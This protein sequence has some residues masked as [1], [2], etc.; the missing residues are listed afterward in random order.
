[1]SGM[2]SN[3]P[4]LNLKG[5]GGGAGGIYRHVRMEGIAR[6]DGSLVCDTLRVDGIG[7]VE[8]EVT[9]LEG[10]ELHGKIKVDGGMSAPKLYVEGQAR[11]N[12]RLRGGDVLVEGLATIT[13][14]CE[15]ERL[16]VE[17]GFTVEGLLNAGDIEIFLQGRSEV[18]EMGGARIR[19]STSGR[20]N[21]TRL[22][23][24]LIPYFQ[25]HLTAGLIEG[26]DLEIEETTAE[27]VRGN[28]VVIGP[29][30][31]IRHVEYGGQLTIHPSARVG[32]S[33]QR[34]M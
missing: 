9:C 18:R 21:W 25:P 28:R 22:L 14:D 29:G 10:C 19:V 3:K 17:G 12:G 16:Q 1:M 2:I 24:W 23:G 8:G 5:I 20:S 27:A 33:V 15:A 13:G 32:S 6:V 34:L 26:D 11:W 31:I 4:D 30:C 7:T